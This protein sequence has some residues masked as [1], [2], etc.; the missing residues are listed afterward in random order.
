MQILI[1]K[2]VAKVGKELNKELSK[3]NELYN[4]LFRFVLPFIYRQKYQIQIYNPY[5]N[6]IKRNYPKTFAVVKSGVL[7]YSKD[8][9]LSIN[10]SEIGYIT[11][12]LQLL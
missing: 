7:F 9:E 3:D 4:D 10:D 5:L 2:L 12:Y 11:L 6:E 1:K 8:M